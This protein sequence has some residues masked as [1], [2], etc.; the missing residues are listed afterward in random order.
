MII[1]ENQKKSWKTPE[2]I[3]MVRS[4]PEEAVMH[5]CKKPTGG[6]GPFSTDDCLMVNGAMCVLLVK[7]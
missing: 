2:L 6:S 4:N 5:C 7:S 1:M 3:V